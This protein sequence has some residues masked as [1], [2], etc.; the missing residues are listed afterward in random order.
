MGL[1]KGLQG[2]RNFIKKF[3][4]ATAGVSASALLANGAQQIKQI[5]QSGDLAK[6]ELDRLSKAYSDLD[7]R[8]QLIMRGMFVLLGIDVLLLV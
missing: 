8:T 7:K 1:D 6:D 5:K 3:G 2:R 4:I